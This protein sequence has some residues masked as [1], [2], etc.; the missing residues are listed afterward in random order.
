MI[1]Y[2]IVIINC[3]SHSEFVD[4]VFLSHDEAMEHASDI[5]K[6]L[7]DDYITDVEEYFVV[8]AEDYTVQEVDYDD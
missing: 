1:V 5:E 4:S 8:G 7:G 2:I 6:E 3:L